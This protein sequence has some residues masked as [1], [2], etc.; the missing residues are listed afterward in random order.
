MRGK[1]TSIEREPQITYCV[2]A[3]RG[4]TFPME[5]GRYGKHW[6]LTIRV[7]PG[8]HGGWRG[9]HV[10]SPA[11]GQIGGFVRWTIGSWVDPCPW[12]G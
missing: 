7:S 1:L 11:P 10:G 5:R 9:L 8:G 4:Q 2:R 6:P 3:P 12:T